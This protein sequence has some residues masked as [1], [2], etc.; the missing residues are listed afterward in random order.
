[1][2]R[3]LIVNADDCNLTPGVT[4]AILECHERGIVSSTTW[5]VNLPIDEK[6]LKAIRGCKRLGIGVHLNVTLGSPVSLRTRVKTLLESGGSFKKFQKQMAR[7]PKESELALEYAG[8]IRL[9]QEIFGRLPTHLDTH[10]QLHDHP[11]FFRALMKVASQYRLPIRRSR[12]MLAHRFYPYPVKRG[13]GKEGGTWRTTDFFFG[14][15]SPSGYWRR[16]ALETLLRN[17]PEGMS[18]IMCHPGRN[19]QALRALSSFTTG[20]EEEFRLFR[21]GDLRKILKDH[22]IELT[23]FGGCSP[24]K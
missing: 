13:G 15:F 8:Q 2:K 24:L 12:L 3:L 11:L 22:S 9:F 4:E 5:L 6:S 16:E 14:N 23:H 1:V 19:T 21:S 20:R 18:E 17:L 7:L 10:H